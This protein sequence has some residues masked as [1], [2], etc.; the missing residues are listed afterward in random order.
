MQVAHASRVDQSMVDIGLSKAERLQVLQRSVYRLI[1]HVY[2][3][4]PQLYAEG[5]FQSL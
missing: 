5:F 1:R 2:R 3:R 4:V